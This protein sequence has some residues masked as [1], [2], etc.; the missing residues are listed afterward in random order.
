[1]PYRWRR[2]LLL[3]LR[4]CSN[5]HFS[6]EPSSQD[7]INDITKGFVECW[8]V[9]FIIQYVLRRRFMNR[10]LG[11]VGPRGNLSKIIARRPTDRWEALRI[12][13]HFGMEDSEPRSRLL[14]IAFAH[15][16]SNSRRLYEN[17]LDRKSHRSNVVYRPISIW[18][19][20]AA[21]LAIS[22]PLDQRICGTWRRSSDSVGISIYRGNWRALLK[23]THTKRKITLRPLDDPG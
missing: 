4:S 11:T 3:E 21:G 2:F 7:F 17:Q 10:K 20:I 9:V 12:L 23:G 19:E 14:Y 22:E 18:K 6:K 13:I 1:M 16:T 5:T 8:T 15:I